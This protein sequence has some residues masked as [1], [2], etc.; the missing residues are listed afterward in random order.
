MI[1]TLGH[2]ARWRIITLV[3]LLV[4]S[5]AARA[6][7]SEC[8]GAPEARWIGKDAARAMAAGMGYKVRRITE[9]DGCYL[10]K[11]FDANG[12][13]IELK[14]DPANGAI[15]RH[16]EDRPGADE[17]PAREFRVRYRSS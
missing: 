6:D 13:R 3:I 9:D 7:D 17:A 10:V 4:G 12:A 8:S 1:G 14:V 5:G 15:V 11:G 2:A 16:D